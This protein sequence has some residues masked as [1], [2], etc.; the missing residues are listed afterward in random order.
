ME[1]G[2]IREFLNE[3]IADRLSPRAFKKLTG[4]RIWISGQWRDDSKYTRSELRSFHARGIPVR[5]PKQLENIRQNHE[6]WSLKKFGQ[7]V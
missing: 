6:R 5:N 2:K 4:R 1:K 7:V 3:V